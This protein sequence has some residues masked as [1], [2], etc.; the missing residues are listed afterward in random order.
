VEVLIDE[1]VLGHRLV[2]QEGVLSQAAPILYLQVLNLLL[3]TSRPYRVA[4]VVEV[5]QRLQRDRGFVE[6]RVQFTVSTLVT[7]E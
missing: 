1:R 7:A 6:V 5:T 4:L 2:L 3:T